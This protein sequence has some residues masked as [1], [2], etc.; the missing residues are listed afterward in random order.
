MLFSTDGTLAERLEDVDKTFGS[1]EGVAQII[2][3]VRAES[4]R[5]LCVPKNS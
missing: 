3:F 5:S 1:D 4:D 2:S